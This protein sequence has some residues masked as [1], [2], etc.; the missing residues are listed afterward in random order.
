MDLFKFIRSLLGI[1]H[2]TQSKPIALKSGVSHPNQPRPL[3][4]ES[5]PLGRLPSELIVHIAGFLPPESALLFSICCWPL[6]SILEAQYLKGL[7]EDRPLDRFKFLTLLERDLP[8]Y[9]TCYYC[10][11]LHAITEAHLY[12]QK[13]IAGR[14]L[15]CWEADM[16]FVTDIFIYRGF[17]ITVFQMT[18]KA[19]RQGLDCS[20]LL[21]L[22]SHKTE[23]RFERGCV[24]QS[25][26]LA[27]I[28]GCSLL[29]REQRIFLIP[30]TQPVQVPLYSSFLVCI[31]SKFPQPKYEKKLGSIIQC[32]YCLTEFR[33]DIKSFEEYG[34]A[35]FV[36]KWLDL[37]EGR[38]P[39]DY[40][41]QSHV[42]IREGVNW[43]PVEFD[44]GS[45]CASFEQKEHFKFE[46]DSL[47]TPQDKKELFTLPVARNLFVAS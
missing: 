12:K 38:S 5:S 15:L 22:L 7:G 30:P 35:I 41:L 36:T 2:P 1:S 16:E 34:N 42:A 26:A 29:T 9:I 18:M 24:E 10:K 45:I 11:R 8:N 13:S 47:L 20:R 6:Y 39:L 25:T 19:Y 40:K 46:F 43:L 4:L 27:R 33:I 14:H 44:R 21:R 23:T 32:N 3:A 31:H 37:G 28:V 17:S